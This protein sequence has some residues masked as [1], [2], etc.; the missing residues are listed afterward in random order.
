MLCV[1]QNHRGRVFM[2]SICFIIVSRHSAS[3]LLKFCQISQYQNMYGR[4]ELRAP[5]S[6]NHSY[7]HTTYIIYLY[8]PRRI[9]FVNSCNYTRLKL[10]PK[11]RSTRVL[12][13]ARHKE[14]MGIHITLAIMLNRCCELQNSKSD[15]FSENYCLLTTEHLTNV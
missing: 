10:L 9:H 1:S 14:V 13:S 7:I 5:G 12:P 6:K 2:F 8:D 4:L 3:F 15:V 11:Y